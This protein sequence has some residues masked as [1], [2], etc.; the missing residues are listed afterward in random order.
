MTRETY[1]HRQFYLFRALNYLT[2]V[3]V[4]GVGLRVKR[5]EGLG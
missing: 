4:L 5:W 3:V 2:V 1:S